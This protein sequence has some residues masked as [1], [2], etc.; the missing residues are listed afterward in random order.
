MSNKAFDTIRFIQSLILPLSV[1]VAALADI[2]G[3]PC[4]VQIAAALAALDVFG[5]AFIDAARKAYNKK[6]EICE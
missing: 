5:G 2:F 3:I 6:A 1:F 4:G